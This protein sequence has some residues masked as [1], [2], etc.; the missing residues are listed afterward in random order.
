MS[1][2][3]KVLLTI[4][5]LCCGRADTTERCLKSLLPIR[6]ALDSEILVIDT[7]CDTSTRAIVD[8]YADRV[9]KF[10]WVNDFAA[11]RNEMVKNAYGQ[12]LLFLDDDE[13]FIDSEGIVNLF[14]SGQYKEYDF[15]SYK[16]R[17]Y[18]DYEGETYSDS[19]VWRMFKLD[20]QMHFVGKIH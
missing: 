3:N 19:D 11:A 8:K 10:T 15:G 4:S 1:T 2:K 17:N 9:V 12:W 6:N 14:L 18:K 16:I 13:F 7:G 20:G 5:L